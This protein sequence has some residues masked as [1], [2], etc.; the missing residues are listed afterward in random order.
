MIIRHGSAAISILLVWALVL[1]DIVRGLAPPHL[2]R[3]MPFSAADGPL[4]IQSA[5]DTPATI[6]AALSRLLDAFLV[7]HYAV[8]A[9]II[10]SVL[11]HR[12]DSN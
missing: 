7:G 10:A 2:S 5:G 11:L 9:V 4:G 6:A 12:R 3:L 8:V 1:E